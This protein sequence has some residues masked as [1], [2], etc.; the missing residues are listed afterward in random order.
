[1]SSIPCFN[2][3]IICIAVLVWLQPA[4]KAPYGL[5]SPHRGVEENGKKQEETGG[6]G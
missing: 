3:I 6:L 2:F 5:P 4:T 1:M